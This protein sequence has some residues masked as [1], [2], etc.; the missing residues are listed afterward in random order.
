MPNKEQTIVE[1]LAE[2]RWRFL[3]VLIWFGLIFLV[4][5]LFAAD[6]YKWLTASF[7]QKLI[8]LGP[9]DILWIYISLASLVAFSLTLPF[10]VYQIW[11]FIRPALRNSEA[12]AIFAYIPATFFSFVLGLAFGQPCYFASFALFRRWFICRPDDSA[13]LSVLSVS[14]DHSDC[15]LV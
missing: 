9:D 7:E 3:A 10:M 2:F 4:S 11:E 8:V 15:L 13:E 12:K 1:H 5:L 14:H 6:I